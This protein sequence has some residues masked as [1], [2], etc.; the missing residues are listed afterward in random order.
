MALTRPCCCPGGRAGEPRQSPGRRRLMVPPGRGWGVCGG[1]QLNL[2]CS[3][4]PVFLT[5]INSN[6]P[7]RNKDK[8]GSPVYTGCLYQPQEDSPAL[9]PWSGR[10]FGSN[11]CSYC[12]LRPMGL[13]LNQ[14]QQFLQR[15]TR[16][17][18][19]RSCCRLRC[20]HPS[21]TGLGYGQGGAGLLRQPPR[22]SEGR[23]P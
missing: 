18:A 11:L 2:V 9:G 12:Q 20:S 5:L 22:R 6:R 3:L 21:P 7:L 14:I 1:G 17:G 10:S 19:E 16:H 23:T 13:C 8:M 15:D 4:S